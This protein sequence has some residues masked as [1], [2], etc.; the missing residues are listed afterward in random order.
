M[1]K[2]RKNQSVAIRFGPAIKALLICSLFVVSGVGYVWQKSLIAD[3][4]RH[5]TTRKQELARLQDQNKK[6][7]E[8]L[9]GLT[10]PKQLN[11]RLTELN[12]GLVEPQPAQVWRLPEPAVPPPAI[13]TTAI[14]QYAA[15]P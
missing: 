4:S 9:A 12:L 1:A 7:R 2:N 3:L 14:K 15:R 13:P 11:K 5:F 8:H 6:L 10:S